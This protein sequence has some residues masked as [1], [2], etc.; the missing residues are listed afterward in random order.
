MSNDLQRRIKEFKDAINHLVNTH[1]KYIM[2]PAKLE[3][4]IAHVNTKRMPCT[5]GNTDMAKRYKTSLTLKDGSSAWVTGSTLQELTQNAV[6]R[7]SA[8]NIVYAVSEMPLLNDYAERWYNI[9]WKAKETSDKA[10]WKSAHTQVFTHIQ[11]HFD[12]VRLDEVKISDVQEFLNKFIEEGRSASTVSKIHMTLRQIF[13]MAI[14][15]D[16]LK[17]NPAASK[18]IEVGN[19]EEKREPLSEAEV[20]SVLAELPSLSIKDQLLILIPLYAGTRRGETLGLQWKHVDFEKETITIEQACKI[21]G[22]KSTLGDTK[23]R[24]GHRTIPLTAPLKNILLS[25]KGEPEDYIVSGNSL[26]TQSAYNRA[27]ERITKHIN[28]FGKTAHSLRH[29][30][31]T[32]MHDFIANKDLQYIMG[33]SEFSTTMDIYVHPKK[34]KIA[35]MGQSLG[36]IYRP[37]VSN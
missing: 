20:R 30:Y 24:S 18:R 32:F 34:E 37:G 27:W 26:M 10:T 21:N 35:A 5:G 16:L 4:R 15:D 17:K 19:K 23:S 8:G 7:Y 1:E 31:A 25:L 3:N 28:M 14:E 2:E 12:G 6:E 29:T 22:N 13:D 36:D 9:T 11:P 33:H